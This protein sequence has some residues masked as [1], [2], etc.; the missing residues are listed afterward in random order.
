MTGRDTGAPVTCDAAY[1]NREYLTTF[2]SRRTV[3]VGTEV[4]FR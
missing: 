2:F 3:V 4:Q 1:Q